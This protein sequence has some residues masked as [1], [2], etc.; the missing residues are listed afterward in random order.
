VQLTVEPSECI[1]CESVEVDASINDGD[2]PYRPG[3]VFVYE[4]SVRNNQWYKETEKSR[5]AISYGLMDDPTSHTLIIGTR[6]PDIYLGDA[7]NF[8]GDFKVPEGVYSGRY[9]FF[10]AASDLETGCSGIDAEPYRVKLMRISTTSKEEAWE[11]WLE[12]VE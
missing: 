10:V 4:V 11:N 1:P 7:Y 5:I 2:I 3:D 8:S 9:I 6:M 12:I